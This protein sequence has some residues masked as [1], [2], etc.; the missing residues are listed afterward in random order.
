MNTENTV[1]IPVRK[2]AIR[3]IVGALLVSGSLGYI[4]ATAGNPAIP[5]VDVRPTVVPLVDVGGKAD[6]AGKDP[7]EKPD[8]GGGSKNS[9]QGMDMFDLLDSDEGLALLAQTLKGDARVEALT[10]I[11]AAIDNCKAYLKHPNATAEGK[12]EAQ[13]DIDR[14]SALIK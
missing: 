11:T 4:I 10:Q 13:D 2:L 5:R 3:G 7:N 12:I 1:D 6:T 14:L 9:F 8:C